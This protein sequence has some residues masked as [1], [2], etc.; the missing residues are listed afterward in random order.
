M[1]EMYPGEPATGVYEWE[2]YSPL[3]FLLLWS[4]SHHAASLSNI[5]PS[6]DKP[7]QLSCAS[8]GRSESFPTV[9]TDLKR[10]KLS[11]VACLRNTSN[12]KHKLH[13]QQRWVNWVNCTIWVRC[14][15]SMHFL[16][17]WSTDL[18]WLPRL[19]VTAESRVG[20]DTKPSLV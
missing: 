16:G 11:F 9:Q 8:L 2:G 19:A 14:H 10:I 13:L 6:P 12:I 1:K 5:S 4:F 18:S 7:S 3:D 17:W 20:D 15:C